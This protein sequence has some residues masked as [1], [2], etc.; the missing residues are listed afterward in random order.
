MTNGVKLFLF[1]LSSVAI[2]TNGCS[3]PYP[4][5]RPNIVLI[6]GDDHGYPYFG[7]MGS[8]IV[9]TPNMDALAKSGMVFSHGYVPEN[10]CRPALNS[11]VTGLLPID[12][13]KKLDSIKYSKMQT[14]NYLSLSDEEK[15]KWKKEFGYHGLQHFMTLPK[16]LQSIGYKSFQS[17]KWWEYHYEY[18]GFTDGMT[19]GWSWGMRDGMNWFEQLMGGEGIDIGRKTNQPVYDFIDKSLDGP[20]FVWYGPSLPHYPFDAPEKFLSLYE[21][22]GYSKSA[23]S[24]Y[25]N[26]TWFDECV[27]KLIDHLKSRGVYDNTL[28]IYVNDN[29]WDQ[30]P[31]D[32]YSDDPMRSHN[33]G[34]KGKLSITDLSYRT[35]VI[36]SWDSVIE[37][38]SRKS[39]LVHSTDIP[40]TILDLVGLDI[41]SN[42]F[43]KSLKRMIA[44]E[45]QIER[46]YIYGNSKKMRDESDEMGRDVENLWLRKGNWFFRWNLTD[47]E[48][49]LYDVLNDPYCNLNLITEQTNIS[50][51]LK[52]ILVKEYENR[53]ATVLKDKAF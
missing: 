9:Q 27:G 17:G 28:F 39:E 13:A 33:G 4:N 32:E 5:N 15:T 38:E 22:K 35:P 7:F 1:L 34:D 40:A 6:I 2:F 29:G 50:E 14:E 3:R 12:Y 47:D 31:Y 42:Y 8:E 52:S 10:H 41:P 44:G 30:E 46:P 16:Q 37:G 11:L 21:N 18:G 26:C 19:K 51:D 45:T 49:Y 36:F 23:V 25:A 48:L 43:G 20:F 24:Y 53:M